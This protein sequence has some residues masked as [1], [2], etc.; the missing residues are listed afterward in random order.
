[1][2]GLHTSLHLGVIFPD[3]GAVSTGVNLML[4]KEKKS[5]YVKLA[6][7]MCN[8]EAAPIIVKQKVFKSCLNASLLY[9]CEAW[10]SSSL[11]KIETLYRKAITVTFSISIRTPNEIV[12]LETGLN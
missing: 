7:F 4:Y 10:S 5:V 6:N 8:N 2:V 9:G 3:S 11:V 12:F 1:M